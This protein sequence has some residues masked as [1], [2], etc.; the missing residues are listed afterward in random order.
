M[1]QKAFVDSGVIVVQLPGDTP[2]AGCTIPEDV[3]GFLRSHSSNLV[4]SET[5]STNHLLPEGP[6]FAK[7]IDLH[8]AWRLYEDE[9]FSFVSAVIP[10]DDGDDFR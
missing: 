4:F 2:S 10:A 9:M 3:N 6:Y 5:S 1:F 7:G 8:Q